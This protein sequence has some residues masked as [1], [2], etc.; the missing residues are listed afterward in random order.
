[1]KRNIKCDNLKGILIFL[2]VLAHLLYS[3]K[4]YNNSFNV[5]ITYFIYTFHM[6]LFLIISGMFSQT[7]DKKSLLNILLLFILL[8]LSYILFDY[9]LTD[10]LE[11]L[12]IKYSAW[13]LIALFIYRLIVYFDKKDIIKK[14]RIPFLVSLFIVTNLISLFNLDYFN[15]IISYSF[16][17]FFG[18]LINPQELKLSKKVSIVALIGC[19][20]LL[21]KIASFKLGL[22][23]FMAYPV[24]NW[25]YLILRII[26]Y[27]IDIVLFV[28]MYNLIS[29]KKIPLIS[30]WGENS[31]GIYIFHRIITIIITDT[32]I[33][34]VYF[35]PVI[36]IGAILICFLFG[37]KKIKSYL[38][39]TKYIIITITT[40]LFLIG[41]NYFYHNYR[42]F[43]KPKYISSEEY[44]EISNSVSLGFVGDL[45]LLENQVK[46]SYREGEYNFD[47]MFS[48]VKDYFNEVDYMMGVLEGPVSDNKPYSVGNFSDNKVLKLNYPSSFIE[49]IKNSGIDLVTIANNHILDQDI[50]GF[51]DTINNLDKYNLEYVGSRN[52]RTKI[53]KVKNLKIGVLAYTYGLNYQTEDS[54]FK[55]L[56]VTNYIVPSQSK[57]FK[58]VKEEVTQDFLDLKKENVDLIVV[59]PH[60]GTQ[61]LTKADEMQKTWNKIFA[62]LGADIVLGSHAHS[63]Q[64]VEY[65]GDT[66]EFNCVGNFVNSYIEHDGDISF[67]SKVY[68]NP[69][70][71]KV[72][73]G[74]IIPLLA[75]K[76]KNL[77]YYA[78]PIYKNYN[79]LEEYKDKMAYANSLVTKVG[80][81]Q[82]IGIN[83][84]EEEYY[85]FKDGYKKHLK[86]D[87]TLTS[88]DKISNMYQTIDKG[89]NIC[90]I[91]DSITEGTKNG[92][93]PWYKPLMEL[94]KDK[95]VYN[96]SKG[97]YTSKDIID[98]FQ[99]KLA[100]S[101]CDVAIIN[102]GTNDIRYSEIKKEEYIENINKI[103]DFLNNKEIVLLAPFRTTEQDRYLKVDA[104]NKRFLY[105]E[106]DEELKKIALSKSNVSFIDINSY[107]AKV[108]KE[109]GEDLFL[110][111]GVHPNNGYGVLLYSYASMRE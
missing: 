109:D 94:F 53:I 16:F 22:N 17:F 28:S 46:D 99:D 98:N 39:N 24:L 30:T 88:K 68:I 19:F 100:N 4:Y 105:E 111:D 95:Q 13:Y 78:L 76:D 35:Y 36:I 108:L 31:L 37:N 44:K 49:S 93:V 89:Q 10:N 103:I 66:L 63:V 12:V 67:I 74:G 33:N 11:F 8:N 9:L 54:L 107:I 96:Y 110:L 104:E 57:Y 97:G 38:K 27:L 32:F 71:K 69:Q 82:N 40:L 85:I 41:V 14:Y 90:F 65:I 81:G 2:V 80:L 106:Y 47:Y 84:M 18:Y 51:R 1:M 5:F 75:V 15:R 21:F 61:F 102:I 20:L 64:P 43:L 55:D 60:Y 7:K 6:P 72:I 86:N 87:L 25:G 56:K 52:E 42:S 70:T 23:F 45:I 59:L 101:L 62:N 58:E 77:G 34:S 50:E 79:I 92:Y 73:G 26:I 83:E 3:F 29:D 91:G 48:L